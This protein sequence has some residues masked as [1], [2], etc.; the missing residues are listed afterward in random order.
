MT[1]ANLLFSTALQN[2]TILYWDPINETFVVERPNVWNH[3]HD[4]PVNHAAEVSPH[5]LF[6]YITEPSSDPGANEDREET[7]QIHAF[8]DSSVLEIFI[9]ERTAL[10]TR[11]YYPADLSD[12]SSKT[13]C[14]G[15]NFFAEDSADVNGTFSI[16]NEPV[17]AT[18]LHATVWDGLEA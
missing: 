1:V 15:I 16:E 3:H 17:I 2:R 10:S 13:S 7:L 18:L 11:I 5:T 14:Y 6:T 4:T 8:Y 12:D 9:N